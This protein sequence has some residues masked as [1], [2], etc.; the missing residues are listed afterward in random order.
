MVEHQVGISLTT[1][2]KVTASGR[3]VRGQESWNYL[4]I[5]TALLI[6]VEGTVLQ[7]I[8]VGGWIGVIAFVAL[9]ALTIWLCLFNGYTQNALI[10]LKSWYETKQY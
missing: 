3:A 8:P 10:K 2:S 4:Y 9:M 5:V 1:S 6:S 7:L